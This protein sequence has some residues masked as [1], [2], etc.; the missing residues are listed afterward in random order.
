MNIPFDIHLCAYVHIIIL[1][2]EWRSV[3]GHNLSL[4]SAKKVSFND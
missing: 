2:A 4:V 1:V 3:T